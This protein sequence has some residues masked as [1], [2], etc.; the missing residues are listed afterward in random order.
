[1]GLKGLLAS[2]AYCVL[3][4]ERGNRQVLAYCIFLAGN[5]WDSIV[6]ASSK[7]LANIWQIDISRNIGKLW[8]IVYF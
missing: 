8:H 6:F 2:V 4:L 1:M 7:H 5:S 3:F